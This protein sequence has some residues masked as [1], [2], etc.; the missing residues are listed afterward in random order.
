MFVLDVIPLAPGLPSG[1]LSYRSKKRLA[2]GTLVYV[3]LRSK[4]IPAV[5]VHASSV[6]E[7]KASIKAAGFALRGGSL[8]TSGRLPEQIIEA[9]HAVAAYHASSIGSILG[10]LLKEALPEKLPE[11]F[12]N[13]PGFTQTFVEDI[14]TNRIERYKKVIKNQS[15]RTTLIVAP[16]VIEAERLSR[17]FKNEKMTL[18]TGTLR[19]K[20]RSE[21]LAAALMSEIV[22]TTPAFA[23]LPIQ[24]LGTIVVERASAS[25]YVSQ[26]RPYL[27][28][29]IALKILASHRGVNLVYGDLP[30]PVELR[31]RPAAPIRAKLNAPA[32]LIDPREEQKETKFSAIPKEMMKAI[33]AAHTSGGRAAI[34]AVRKGYGAAVVCKDCGNVVRD[35]RGVALSLVTLGEK[36]ML[37]SADGQTKIDAEAICSVCESWNLMPLG[38]GVESVIEEI[39]IALPHAD[40]IRFDADVIRTAAQAKSALKR[41]ADPGAIVVGTEIMLPYLDPELPFEVTAIAS[42]DS[43][44]ALPFWRA[45]ERLVRIGLT[46][47]ERA[48]HFYIATRLPD[49]IAVN[50][51]CNPE[52]DAFFV[53]ETAIRKAF[54]Y[55]PFGHLLV[56]HTEGARTRLD[57]AALRIEKALQPHVAIR[58]SD[59][60]VKRGLFR[61]SM[62]VKLRGPWPDTELSDRLSRL[63]PSISVPLDPESLW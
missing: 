8:K 51:L 37:R 62:I 5:V 27:N 28:M 60:L 38:I 56:F 53:E 7:A 24:N 40:V 19:G 12:H 16:T 44:L 13:G 41:L 18:V 47:R 34:L 3:P 29:R 63:P 32:T 59:R 42:A 6:I 2:P 52:H 26:K 50:T 15:T 36:R 4:D 55:P 46:L 49:D 10:A 25:G 43:L 14:Y 58:L 54:F 57:E 45:R 39:K 1:T 61:L 21:A 22:V 30:L 33:V 9:A 31:P 17:T 35:E 48:R 23:W 11:T 20:R